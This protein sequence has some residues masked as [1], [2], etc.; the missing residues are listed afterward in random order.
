[1]NLSSVRRLC[2]EQFDQ[3]QVP[4]KPFGCVRPQ[5][6]EEPDFYS[7]ADWAIIRTIW[8][9]DLR[10]GLPERQRLEWIANLASQVN[11]R[12]GSYPT[13]GG[14]SKLHG[15]GT[16]I[17]AFGALGGRMPAPVRL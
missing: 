7:S 14:H 2:L 9:E 8:G 6:G 11:P 4:G 15:N 13:L 3:N 10:A 16:A 5:A 12:D 17:G 1:M